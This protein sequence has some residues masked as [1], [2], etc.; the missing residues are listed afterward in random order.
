[1]N[2]RAFVAGLEPCSPRRARSRRSRQRR[3]GGLVFSGL[4]Y[5]LAALCRRSSRDSAN[6]DTLKDA[7]SGSNT[8]IQIRL[9]REGRYDSLS[10]L[11]SWSNSGQ[12]FSSC[13]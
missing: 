13:L 8:V 5:P 1:M 10:S 6:S 12:M 9:L 11:P 2:R 7:I 4:R 3:S